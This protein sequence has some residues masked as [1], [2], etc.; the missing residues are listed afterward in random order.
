[1][2][3]DDWKTEDN[4]DRLGPRLRSSRPAKVCCWC[5]RPHEIQAGSYPASH[6]M[7]PAAAA[8]QMALID[9]E[10]AAKRQQGA[11]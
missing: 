2:S 11:A 4:G 8:R 10:E 7:C 9:A 6:G 3:Y 1:M 5:E